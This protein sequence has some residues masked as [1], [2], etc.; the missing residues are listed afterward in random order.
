MTKDVSSE[1]FRKSLECSL[2]SKRNPPSF[3]RTDGLLAPADEI[4]F[5]IH[6]VATGRKVISEF[7]LGHSNLRRLD[8]E[9]EDF[10]AIF[11]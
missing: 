3:T 8:R 11:K 4:P 6:N 1:S 2:F 7:S 9:E 5:K 10:C